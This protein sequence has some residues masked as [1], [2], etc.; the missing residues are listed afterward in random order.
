MTRTRTGRGAG[1]VADPGESNFSAGWDTRPPL[2]GIPELIDV[3]NDIA[4]PGRPGA[5]GPSGPH[6]ASGGGRQRRFPMTAH[7]RTAPRGGR[8]SKIFEERLPASGLHQRFNKIPPDHGPAGPPKKALRLVVP[9]QHVAFPGKHRPP[10]KL[11]DPF[12]HIAVPL[13]SHYRKESPEPHPPWGWHG[14]CI[15]V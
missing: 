6:N 14:F 9:F 2:A 13:F 7:H 12:P 5:D 11:S 8:F 15:W 10:P 1:P 4:S 3:K